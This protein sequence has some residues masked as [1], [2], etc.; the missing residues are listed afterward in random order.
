MSFI[1]DGGKRRGNDSVTDGVGDPRLQD[2][3]F[4][5]GQATSMP[6]SGSP[7]DFSGR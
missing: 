5:H 6:H 4:K 7:V 2:D 1:T 3:E